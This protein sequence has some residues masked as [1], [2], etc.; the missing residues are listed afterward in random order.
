MLLHAAVLGEASDPPVAPA[1][2]DCWLVGE[3][4]AGEWA[5]RGGELACRQEGAWQF[6]LP[7]PGTRVYD[8]ANGQ[9]LLFTDTWRR[10]AAP[11]PPAGGA[12]VDSEAR[13]TIA[14]LIEALKSAGIFASG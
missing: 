6:A 7:L 8:R 9:M 13:D 11:S 4:P 2:G 5:G 14:T 3:S 10:I 12:T 1:E